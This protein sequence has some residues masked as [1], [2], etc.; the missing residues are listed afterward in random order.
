[1]VKTLSVII[2]AY[3][4]EKTIAEVIKKVKNV[5]LDNLG[6]K[7]EIIVISDGSNDKTV[8]LA[9]S[10]KGV[11]VIDKQP[12]QGKG[13]AVR[14]GIIEAK[15]DIII[16]QDADLEYNPEEYS[17]IVMPIL[18]GK[19]EVVYG[20]RFLGSKPQ[21]KGF[22]ARKHGK[23]YTSAYIGARIVTVITNLLFGLNLTDEATC[24]KCF[25]ADVI[26]SIS[27]ERNRFD[28]EPE[29]TAKIGRKGIKIHE[30]PI[31]YSP[32]SFKEGKKINWKDGVQALWVL[33]KYR[34]KT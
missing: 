4:E 28:W 9:S 21:G 6:L 11:R 18:A 17:G 5:N 8:E 32:R 33:F 1:M 34:L 13:S 7:K 19:A 31:T 30:V 29:V 27:I 22:F 10:I 12:N 25:K 26:K 24:Y 3:N 14:K 2:P 16:I 20:S 23:A 15:G